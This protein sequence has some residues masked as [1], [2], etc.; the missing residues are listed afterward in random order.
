[1]HLFFIYWKHV[2][3]RNRFLLVLSA[4]HRLFSFFFPSI[5]SAFGIT[6]SYYRRTPG[7]FL[8]HIHMQ[9]WLASN[10]KPALWD[11]S[12]R[13][14][15]GDKARTLCC[16]F[17][18]DT[19]SSFSVVLTCSWGSRLWLVRLTSRECLTR[20]LTRPLHRLQVLMF[21]TKA[22]ACDFE[23]SCP[24]NG[25]G[26]ISDQTTPINMGTFHRRQGNL[27][28]TTG[29]PTFERFC[30]VVSSLKK[31]KCV[32]MRSYAKHLYITVQFSFYVDYVICLNEISYVNIQ[33]APV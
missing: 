6:D 3:S 14:L 13:A 19:A 15:C 23:A 18:A 11:R 8:N 28:N 12:L 9:V 32:R 16:R 5:V 4:F 22:I 20:D 21:T 25:G 26:I 17:A 10:T 29:L 24:I 33:R 27:R 1:M 2:I 30:P 7:T 31:Q